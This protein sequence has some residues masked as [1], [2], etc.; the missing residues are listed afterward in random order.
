WRGTDQRTFRLKNS[1]NLTDEGTVVIDVF[2]RLQTDENIRGRIGE[3]QSKGVCDAKRDVL[4]RAPATRAVD[5]R[6][7]YVKSVDK[8]GA[9]L[10]E[11]DSADAIPGCTIDNHVLFHEFCRKPVARLVLVTDPGRCEPGCR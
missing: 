6:F 1:G 3:R 11:A 10:K 8:F 7:R 5:C 4:V 2:D 9:S